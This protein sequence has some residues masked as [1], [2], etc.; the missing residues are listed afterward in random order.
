MKSINIKAY[1]ED[2]SQIDAL[3][4]FMQA[5]KIKFEVTDDKAYNPEFVEKILKSKKQ[6]DEGKFTEVK[7]ENLKSF[8]NSL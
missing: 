8:I 4:A 3:K 6:I 1:T 2:A 7:Q 5:L